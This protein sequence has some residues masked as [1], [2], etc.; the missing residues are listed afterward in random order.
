MYP[1]LTCALLF[2]LVSLS[3]CA[4]ETAPVRVSIT[5]FNAAGDGR[6]VSTQAIQKAIDHVAQAGGGTVV[7]PEGVYTTGALFLKPGV[8]LYLEKDAVI[9]GSTLI[10]DYPKRL[11]RIEGHFE[12]WRCALLN[13]S[14]SDH[15]RITGEGTIDGSGQPFWQEFWRRFNRCRTAAPDIH[16]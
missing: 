1:R 6:S 11:T 15:L 12:E 2:T 13:A 3:L 4:A 7:V 14:K 9:R 10:D 16:R 5:D 8:N